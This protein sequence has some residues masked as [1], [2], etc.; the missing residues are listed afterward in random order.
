M[1]LCTSPMHPCINRPYTYLCASTLFSRK[2]CRSASDSAAIFFAP[3]RVVHSLI[4]VMCVSRSEKYQHHGHPPLTTPQPMAWHPAYPCKHCRAR[5]VSF[6]VPRECVSG[7]RHRIASEHQPTLALTDVT[8][9]QGLQSDEIP[10]TLEH[11]CTD[12]T[13]IRSERALCLQSG[14]DMIWFSCTC[15]VTLAALLCLHLSYAFVQ[16][17]VEFWVRVKL[18][19]ENARSIK[20]IKSF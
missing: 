18:R 9:P 15:A 14:L 17:S 4:C 16:V 8:F 11:P 12:G 2:R 1:H 10:C 7:L 6:G 19:Q 13:P 3:V 20:F 5:D